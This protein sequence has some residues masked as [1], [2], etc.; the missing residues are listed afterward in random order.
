MTKI[1]HGNTVPLMIPHMNASSVLPP[2]L[3]D[4]P[5]TSPSAMSPY[6]ATML[7]V[8][9]R[10]ANS[11]ER[12]AIFRGLLS[13]REALRS[14]GLTDGYQWLDG[15]FVEDVE[16]VRGRPPE[17]VDIVTFTPI[18]GSLQEKR[19]LVAAN[20]PIFHSKKSREIYRCEAFFVDLTN[21]PL[22]IV[23]HTRYYFGLF[24][25]QRDTFLW[26][27]ILQVPLVSD[28]SA[29]AEW[30][31]MQELGSGGVQNAQEA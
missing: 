24:S 19:A 20:H 5:G 23:G 30:L 3:G 14:L 31:N 6:P 9:Q 17:D 7:K 28:D 16:S 4:D 18:Q 22:I 21:K 26:K 8:A 25:H 13:Y 12:I 15:S 27:G 11:P 29:A 2:F 1:L 10:F